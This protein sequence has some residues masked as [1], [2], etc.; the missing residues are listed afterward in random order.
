[1][2]LLA[3]NSRMKIVYFVVI[4]QFCFITFNAYGGCKKLYPH[5]DPTNVGKWVLNTEISDEFNDKVL[6]EKK[7]LIQGRN[8]E[9]KSKWLGRNPSQFSTE[10]VRIENNMLKLQTR[11]EPNF[12]FANKEKDGY[13]YGKLKTTDST[14]TMPITTAAVIARTAFLYGYM[15]IKC[16]AA[17]ASVTSAFWGT[18]SGMELDVFE[19][20]GKPSIRKKIQLETE[21]WSSIH[22]WSIKGGPSV[23]TDR[24]QLPFRVAS[25]FHVYGLDWS[26][27]GLKFY[28]DG[29]LV[30]EVSKQQV[31]DTEETKKSGSRGW[32]VDKPLY[33][34]VDSEVFP[35]HGMP[36]KEDLPA[37]YEIEYIRVWQKK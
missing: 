35:W 20:L 9:Y 32:V 28:A 5:T 36:L 2:Q 18:G 25:D 21:L 1:M 8:G 11:W 24:L 37:D 31:L 27:D 6:D 7:W 10:N 26:E 29:K 14:Y 23:W 4:M 34:W 12:P 22:D 13:A 33:I 30:R 15:E 19:H 17:D 3:L 16:K